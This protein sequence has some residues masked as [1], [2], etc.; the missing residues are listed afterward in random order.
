MVMKLFRACLRAALLLA[1]V[2]ALAASARAQNPVTAGDPPTPGSSMPDNRELPTK[3]GVQL[4]P[5]PFTKYHT[6]PLE[7]R[8]QREQAELRGEARQKQIVEATSLL[9]QIAQDLRK[10]I[11]SQPSAEITGSERTRL[12]HIQKLAH[13]I[14]DREKTE[15]DISANLAKAGVL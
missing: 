12:E 9:L 11:A 10:E 5:D 6:D 7:L 15:D 2:C 14:R 1:V 4:S 3:P 8:A 13:M